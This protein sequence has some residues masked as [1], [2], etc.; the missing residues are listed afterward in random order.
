MKKLHN[1][2]GETSSKNERKNS[3]RQ[4]FIGF[5]YKR[6]AKERGGGDERVTRERVA[7]NTEKGAEE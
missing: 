5:S 4:K 7:R 3:A 1:E 2:L 6:L